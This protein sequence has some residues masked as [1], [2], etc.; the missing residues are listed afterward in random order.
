MKTKTGYATLL[1]LGFLAVMTL[2]GITYMTAC[3]YFLKTSKNYMVSVKSKY[4]AEAGLAKAVAELKYGEDGAVNNSVDTTKEAWYGDDPYQETID[5][6]GNL[7]GTYTVTKIIDCAS[8]INLNDGNP[9]LD[10]MLASLNTALGS[11]LNPENINQIVSHAPYETKGQLLSI[12]GITETK[13]NA[14]KDYVAVCGYKDDLVI[15][16]DSEYEPPASFW[17]VPGE[18]P[19]PFNSRTPININTA[20]EEVLTAMLTNLTCGIT[21]DYTGT[22]EPLQYGPS[23]GELKEIDPVTILY[24]EAA[25][26]SQA[27]I[28]Y[29][30]STPFT[31]WKQFYNFL[32]DNKNLLTGTVKE[33]NKKKDS[34]YA[35]FNP[36]T[37]FMNLRRINPNYSW[38]KMA[39]KTDL[40]ANTTEGSFNSGG[41]YQ[42][43]AQGKL[44]DGLGGTLAKKELTAIVKLFDTYKE[45]TQEQF[46]QGTLTRLQSYPEPQS[47]TGPVS[48]IPPATYD[49]QLMIETT[50]TSDP[51][52]P[53]YLKLTFTEGRNADVAVDPLAYKPYLCYDMNFFND[54]SSIAVDG[55]L[56]PDGAFFKRGI[57]GEL[58]SRPRFG[59]GDSRFLST[60]SIL[61]YRIFGGEYDGEDFLTRYG[62]IHPYKL[63]VSFWVKQQWDC[64]DISSGWDVRKYWRVP[65]PWC[66]ATVWCKKE[67]Q[68]IQPILT[69]TTAGNSP[70][71]YWKPGEWHHIV[72]ASY[73]N[74]T[75]DTSDEAYYLDGGTKSNTRFYNHFRYCRYGKGCYVV[76]RI[77]I[78]WDHWSARYEILNGTID[79]FRISTAYEPG[80]MAAEY[81]EGRYYDSG[82]RYFISKPKD[83]GK[84][85]NLGIVTWTEH[86]PDDYDDGTNSVIANADITV[87]VKGASTESGLSSASWSDTF[88][89]P[90][91]D[92]TLNAQARFIQ[93]KVNFYA[94]AGDV[95]G[96]P[97]LRDTPVF[98]DITITH[99]PKTRVLYYRW[100]TEEE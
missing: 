9:H 69:I 20:T 4:L 93:Y 33:I 25:S 64:M 13:Y 95:G 66:W 78:G 11:P 98:D 81:L 62:Q 17:P 57:K 32:E 24:T 12:P 30:N 6:G 80:V 8:Q 49:G 41:Y 60:D 54:N 87:Q 10:T 22:T 88:N 96:Y 16:P 91:S 58:F 99:L 55:S 46:E 89:N 73:G 27:I 74:L 61:S 42:I 48:Q 7:T 97:S 53:P 31:N 39:G 37:D 83:L 36:N 34:V 72:Q 68:K 1:V 38:R 85:R 56:M 84:E 14:I 47:S 70:V 63:T 21:Y 52:G 40:S 79:E 44:T 76:D 65:G 100:V 29:R 94:D 18:E 71:A 86:L 19:Y 45:T 15:D 75:E 77:D 67:Y 2:Y 50:T 90:A 92:N 26:L 3:C 51:V 35:N 43:Y 82:N 5:L 28:N 23:N 59:Y